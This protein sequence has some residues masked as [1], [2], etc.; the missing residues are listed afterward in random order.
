MPPE[1]HG[2]RQDHRASEPGQFRVKQ[3]FK[4]GAD[5]QWTPAIVEM[6]LDGKPQL[7]FEAQLV[8]QF[9]NMRHRRKARQK[10]DDQNRSS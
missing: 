1:A 10:A 7:A 3:K 5:H 4:R 9:Q 2:T 6:L 8:G